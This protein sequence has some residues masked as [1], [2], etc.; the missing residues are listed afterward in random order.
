MTEPT[1]TRKRKTSSRLTLSQMTKRPCR[2]TALCPCRQIRI[3]HLHP[4]RAHRQLTP[5]LVFPS[6]FSPLRHPLLRR[7]SAQVG[8]EVCRDKIP[9]HFSDN[10]TSH[11]PRSSSSSSN[12]AEWA[13]SACHSS[14]G[15]NMAS[16]KTPVERRS[17]VI[18]V[19]RNRPQLGTRSHHNRL[20]HNS[21]CSRKR[22]GRMGSSS[23]SS[24]SKD[25]KGRRKMPLLISLI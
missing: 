20:K 22:H 8:V 13:I 4:P 11:N 18:S 6:T 23:S 2:A 5:L 24:S 14:K 7:H 16:P 19:F 10:K 25:S 17:E 12:S 9:W 3:L 1:R 21:P 15:S